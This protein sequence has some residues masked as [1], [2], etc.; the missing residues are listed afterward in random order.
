MPRSS[1]QKLAWRKLERKV[2]VQSP[3]FSETVYADA[4]PHGTIIDHTSTH[5]RQQSPISLEVWQPET[6]TWQVISRFHDYDRALPNAKSTIEKE[7]SFR[8]IDALKWK[9]FRLRH[10]E[11]GDIIP[12]DIL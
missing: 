11:T 6:R 5:E 2:R 12:C 4:T 1:V 8:A 7:K 9:T 10:G 3:Y